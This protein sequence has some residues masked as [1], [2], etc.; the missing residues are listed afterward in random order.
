MKLNYFVVFQCV[1]I[2]ALNI[3]ANKMALHNVIGVMMDTDLQLQTRVL[4]SQLI[5]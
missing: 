5:V 2:I 4:V 3:S 1:L